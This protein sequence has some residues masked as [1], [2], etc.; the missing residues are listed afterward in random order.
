LL[1]GLGGGGGNN[2]I[3]FAAASLQ[4][5]TSGAAKKAGEKTTDYLDEKAGGR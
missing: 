3:G 1:R 5:K 4:N 2:G